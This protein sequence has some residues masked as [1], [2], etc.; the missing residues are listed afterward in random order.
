MSPWVIVFLAVTT[1]RPFAPGINLPSPTQE[2]DF[3]P[4]H[5]LAN[6]DLLT[7]FNW[8]EEQYLSRTEGSAIRRIGYERWLR[9]LAV[10]LGNAPSDVNIINALK[11]RLGTISDMLDEHL[12]WALEQQQRPKRR[13][14][15][16]IKAPE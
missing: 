2:E 8:N 5:G 10:G 12:H 1:A 15:R 13:R 3:Q 11:Q 4:R 9:N 6:S 14:K 7:L 16:K